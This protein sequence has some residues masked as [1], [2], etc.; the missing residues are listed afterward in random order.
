MPEARRPR[1]LLSAVLLSA[2]LPVTRSFC[3][4]VAQIAIPPPAFADTEIA[5]HIAVPP[6]EGKSFFKVS[7]AFNAS[8]S[9]S[10]TVAFGVDADGDGRLS[11]REQTVETGW[12]GV[13]F[14][15][16]KGVC[17]WER[18]EQTGTEGRRL[19]EA[20]RW[21]H[22]AEPQQRLAL[23]VDGTP[24]MFGPD[25]ATWLPLSALDGGMARVTARGRGVEGAAERVTGMD[26]IILKLK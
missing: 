16:R 24:P 8:P 22:R 26:G 9:N 17:G 2:L 19:F 1:L 14:I 21:M 12:D 25:V 10:L 3:A 23:S 11:L 18:L 15:R 20:T 6:L 4:D 7:A 13:W 5:T